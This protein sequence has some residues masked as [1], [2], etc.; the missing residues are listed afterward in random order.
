MAALPR[1][2]SIGRFASKPHLFELSRNV[3]S[4]DLIQL[5]IIAEH[6]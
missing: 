1:L 5:N 3:V 6:D 2:K 4:S